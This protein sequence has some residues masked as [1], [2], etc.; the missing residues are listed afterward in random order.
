MGILFKQLFC[1]NVYLFLVIINLVVGSLSCGVFEFRR[2]QFFLKQ[3]LI[4]FSFQL[5]TQEVSVPLP[6]LPNTCC[7]WFS[8]MLVRGQTMLM[9][10]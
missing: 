2:N 1:E 5:V 4:L 3:F 10:L 9:W 8:A 6:L 7:C